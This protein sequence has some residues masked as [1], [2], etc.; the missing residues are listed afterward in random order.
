MK[1]YVKEITFTF[2]R[3]DWNT[4]FTTAGVDSLTI[5]EKQRWTFAVGL[6]AASTTNPMVRHRYNNVYAQVPD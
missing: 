2:W 3:F 6:L 4:Q 1:N 5:A